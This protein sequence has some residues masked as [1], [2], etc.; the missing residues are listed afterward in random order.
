MLIHIPHLLIPRLGYSVGQSLNLHI[1]LFCLILYFQFITP[2][3]QAFLSRFTRAA[4]RSGEEEF[5]KTCTFLLDCHLVVNDHSSH[6]ASHL[7]A[8]AVLA[9]LTLYRAAVCSSTSPP[10]SAISTIWTVWTPTLVHYTAYTVRDLAV[11]AE[12]MLGA[13]KRQCSG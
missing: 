6:L 12:E 4:L 13:L 7:A 10:V 3:P 8:A 11:T 9:A 2:S 5:Y 1:F